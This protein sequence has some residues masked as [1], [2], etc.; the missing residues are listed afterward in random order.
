MS[1]LAVALGLAFCLASPALSQER[2]VNP[3]VNTF[4]EKP[5]M[6]KAASMLEQKHPVIFK[7][8]HAIVAA[9]GIEPGW[10]V[11]DV[12][13]GTGFIAL[14]MARAVGSEGKVYA[15]EISQEHLDYIVEQAEKEGVGNLVPV[16]GG[17]HTTNLPEASMDLVVTIRVY[18]H[19]EYPIDMLASILAALRPG[20]RFV[21]ID[22]ERIKG[23]STPDEYEHWRAGKGTVTDEILDAGF[24]LEKELPLIPDF[25]YLVFRPR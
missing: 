7:Y 6:E 5:D 21:V 14:L 8:R 18:H 9:L 20:G 10:N 16:L 12:G 24:V 1:R 19:F 22:K 4:W 13:A 17:H 2:S 11:A 3:G 15:Q 25:Y 23:V